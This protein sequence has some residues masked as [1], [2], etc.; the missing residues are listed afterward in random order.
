M[1]GMR[2][3]ER[4]INLRAGHYRDFWRVR[5]TQCPEA[6]RFAEG[7]KVAPGASKFYCRR[8]RWS[9]HFCRKFDAAVWL[10]FQIRKYVV[11]RLTY[12]VG[13]AEHERLRLHPPRCVRVANHFFDFGIAHLLNSLDVGLVLSQGC[14]RRVQRDPPVRLLLRWGYFLYRIRRTHA[15]KLL[16]IVCIREVINLLHLPP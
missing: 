11:R 16:F 15:R 12:V 9:L 6:M 5:N 7:L 14:G 10:A 2:D 1:A 13:L 8:C 4:N 3:R